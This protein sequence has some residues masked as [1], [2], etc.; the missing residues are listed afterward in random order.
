MMSYGSFTPVLHRGENIYFLAWFALPL[1]KNLFFPS[2]ML[3]TFVKGFFRVFIRLMGG[4]FFVKCP[5]IHDYEKFTQKQL[6]SNF[7]SGNK[8]EID[9]GNRPNA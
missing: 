9:Q 7:K 4:N 5:G 3:G 8:G 2:D 6:E 1:F